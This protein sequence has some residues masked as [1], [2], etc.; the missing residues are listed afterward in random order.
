[1]VGYITTAHGIAQQL[2]EKWRH[3]ACTSVVITFCTSLF[4]VG[5]QAGVPVRTTTRTPPISSTTSLTRA[6]S[7]ERPGTGTP[8]NF[9]SFPCACLMLRWTSRRA[10]F[11]SSPL[12]LAHR[13]A[14]RASARWIH[15]AEL[16]SDYPPA[17]AEKISAYS[18]HPAVYES[19]GAFDAAFLSSPHKA[20]ALVAR[21]FMQS[22]LADPALR[23]LFQGYHR[24]LNRKHGALDAKIRNAVRVQNRRTHKANVPS[25]ATRKCH[26][27]P[28]DQ[29]RK[30]LRCSRWCGAR[31]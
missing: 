19:L 5:V 4:C 23:V 18:D 16:S 30:R 24:S 27:T 2:S 25:K 3:C 22:K 21:T 28:G 11:S 26:V 17:V 10:W 15:P 9:A 6:L 14:P 12:P 29:C 31:A 7:W 8:R 1:M 13:R 20:K